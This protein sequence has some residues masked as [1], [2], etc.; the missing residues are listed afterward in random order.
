MCKKIDTEMNDTKNDQIGDVAKL[1]WA[2]LDVCA[3]T[4]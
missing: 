3:S 1:F 4:L 2:I